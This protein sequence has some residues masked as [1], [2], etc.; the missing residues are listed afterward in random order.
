[1]KSLKTLFGWC[2]KYKYLYLFVL[3]VII[4]MTVIRTTVPMFFS[5]IL[6][7]I[8]AGQESILMPFFDNI[9]QKGDS[10]IQMVVIALG[11]MM[12]LQVIYA[13]AILIVKITNSTISEKIIK[14]IRNMLYKKMQSIPYLKI[15][16]IDSGDLIQRSTT[17]LDAIRG[18]L[19]EEII[20]VMWSTCYI[21][22]TII[23]ML[24]ISPQYTLISVGL[25]PII[26][27]IMYQ[28]SIK[29]GILFHK[30]DENES[31]LIDTI[32]ENIKGVTVVRSYGSQQF[33]YQKYDKKA[34]VYYENINKLI[35]L[36]SKLDLVTTIILGVQMMLSLFAG[37][38]F[39]NNGSITVGTIILFLTYIKSL[40]GQINL[41]VRIMR[42]FS[43]KI[44]A[45]KRIN[46]ILLEENEPVETL[47]PNI[48][49]N[50]KFNNVSFKYPGENKHILDNVNFE[51]KS[52]EKVAIMGKTGSG[53]ST[54][55]FLLSR[56]IEPVSGTITIDGQD[57]RQ[58]NKEHLRNHIGMIVQEVF[59]FSKNIY[60]NISIKQEQSDANKIYNVAK[61][62]NIH[63]DIMNFN[64][65]YKTIVG[66]RGTTLSGGQKQRIAIARTLI[67]KPKVIFFDDSLSA[68]DNETDYQ[69]R[70]ELMAINDTTIITVTHRMQSI[71]EY[72]KVIVLEQGKIIE[73][74]DVKALLADKTSYF[75]KAHQEQLGGYNE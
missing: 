34:E 59:L 24:I 68:V 25:L 52:G 70:E 4:G 35:I 10:K 69:I 49:G 66:E 54:I 40:N 17:D 32:S 33:E 48:N 46:E 56:L 57:L 43:R 47:T 28:M 44:V 15:K 58:I 3:V 22:I 61:I 72:D 67:N 45:I 16:E 51:I 39:A 73:S 12:G 31:E 20:D 37:V 38:Y 42:H 9:I 30:I 18:F 5:Y 75:A 23:Q 36:I 74:G 19:G 65:G 6:D 63:N 64:D 29:L 62:A 8:L 55:S 1:M 27:V 2:E 21:L 14:S 7:T 41:M 26:A 71:L 13:A 11:L 53:K 50:I 60:D